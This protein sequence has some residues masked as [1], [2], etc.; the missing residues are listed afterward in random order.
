MA[1]PC[2]RLKHYLTPQMRVLSPTTFRRWGDLWPGS[3]SNQMIKKLITLKSSDLFSNCDFMWFYCV[4]CVFFCR[5][6]PLCLLCGPCLSEPACW[7]KKLIKLKSWN[8]IQAKILE[9]VFALSNIYDSGN[10][11]FN[12]WHYNIKCK[13]CI[14]CV[15]YSYPFM[16]V[17][18]C[19]AGLHGVSLVESLLKYYNYNY[20]QEVP[21][22][23]ILKITRQSI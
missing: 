5:E 21:K 10:Q 14:K 9:S 19:V 1:G 2:S 16:C 17:H 22:W 6:A 20:H 8:V 4:H 12:I 3:R 13:L 18:A 23:A 11:L 7:H 15:L